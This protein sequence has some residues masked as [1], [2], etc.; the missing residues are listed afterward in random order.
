MKSSISS[1]FILVV[2]CLYLVILLFSSSP[3]SSLNKSFSGKKPINL[4]FESNHINDPPTGRRREISKRSFKDILK[5]PSPISDIYQIPKESF[6]RY[7]NRSFLLPFVY[8][9]YLRPSLNKSI[10]SSTAV[11]VFLFS[12]GL[13]FRN[14]T[15]SHCLIG[16]TLYPVQSYDLDISCCT[17]WDFSE[18]TNFSEDLLVTAIIDPHSPGLHTSLFHTF[19]L[20]GGHIGRPLSP[21][22]DLITFQRLLSGYNR[23]ARVKEDIQS[24]I[25]LK[26]NTDLLLGLP[27]RLS[28]NNLLIDKFDPV[29]AHME[30]RY[31]VCMSTMTATSPHIILPWIDY[32]RTIGVDHVYIFDNGLTSNMS[33]QLAGRKDVEIIPWPW[34]KTQNQAM[35]FALLS[36]RRRCKVLFKPD[37]DEYALIGVLPED[38]NQPDQDA[39]FAKNRRPLH[40]FLQYRREIFN[41]K[42]VQI[43]SFK[44]CNSGYISTPSG[45]PPLLYTHV[46]RVPEL[47]PGKSFCDTMFDYRLGAIHSCG[48]ISSELKLAPLGREVVPGDMDNIIREIQ[49]EKFWEQY[50]API[51]V[52]DKAWLMH[53]YERSWEEWTEKWAIGK[54]SAKNTFRDLRMNTFNTSLPVP[55]FIDKDHERCTR[56]TFFKQIFLNVMKFRDE[57]IRQS[58]LV[59]STQTDESS[60]IVQIKKT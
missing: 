3:R 21:K 17:V 16:N 25:F 35:A 56:Y 43:K 50:V 19:E 15:V 22:N 30:K 23:V 59:W 46:R 13:N 6:Q 29:N 37:T 18:T 2:S 60:A 24:N 26:E 20:P 36:A 53:F 45:P 9:V 42:S 32:H 52:S 51:F 38:K 33:V 40:A 31:A 5:T 34:K 1:I 55:M 57:R 54:A 28:L 8:H 39:A 58:V 49:P 48:D 7:S 41:W 10:A 47:G 4:D 14:L 27:G 11:D 44:L 12:Q